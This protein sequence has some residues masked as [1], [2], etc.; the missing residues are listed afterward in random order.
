MTIKCAKGIAMVGWTILK[1]N[2]V[3]KAMWENFEEDEATKRRVVNGQ[4]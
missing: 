2:D 4:S 1:N 3:A